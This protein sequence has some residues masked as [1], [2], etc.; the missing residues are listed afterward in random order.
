[1]ATENTAAPNRE[2]DE[3]LA[4]TEVGSF[5]ANNKSMMTIILILAF[6]GVAGFGV[7]NWSSSKRNAE[8]ETAL[9]EYVQGSLKSYSE[10]NIDAAAMLSGYERLHDKVGNYTGLFPIGIE[11]AKTLLTNGEASMA[12]TILESLKKTASNSYQRFMLATNL[13]VAYE[14][15]GKNAEALSTL[16]ELIKSNVGLMEAKIYLDA[17]RLALALGQNDKARANLQWV[18][19]KDTDAEMTLLARLYMSRLEEK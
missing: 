6:A 15:Q 7:W 16:E 14:D 1:M 10:K 9:H 13:A 17:G 5:I 2:I 4:R 3:V 11:S 12:I 18:I 19:D 8:F